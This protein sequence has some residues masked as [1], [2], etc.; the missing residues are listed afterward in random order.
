[1]KNKL[2]TKLK[3]AQLWL[4]RN[5]QLISRIIVGLVIGLLLLFSIVQLI[6]IND[7]SNRIAILTELNKQ[8]NEQTNVLAAQALKNSEENQD[9]AKQNR[10]YSRCIAEI[11]AKHTRDNLPITILNLDTCQV[12]NQNDNLLTM[13]SEGGQAS[14]NNPPAS[15]VPS[16]KQ[17]SQPKRGNSPQ[18]KPRSNKQNPEAPA[19]PAQPQN[20]IIPGKTGCTVNLLGLCI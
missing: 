8:L 9:L 1:M 3:T 18:L 10:A 12:G 4:H 14:P 2:S 15:P 20:S 7:Q 19:S 16:T 5:N 13:P 17:P 11:F 6:K